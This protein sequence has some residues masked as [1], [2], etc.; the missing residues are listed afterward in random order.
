MGPSSSVLPRAA[1]RESEPRPGSHH[2][3]AAKKPP[4][5]RREAHQASTPTRS[6]PR[7]GGSS[8]NSTP[9]P[10]FRG[11]VATAMGSALRTAVSRV[12][13]VVAPRAPPQSSEGSYE[14]IS[15]SPFVASAPPRSREALELP[16]AARMA[17]SDSS[18]PSSL[19]SEVPINPP[20]GRF[21]TDRSQYEVEPQPRATFEDV[22]RA[23]GRLGGEPIDGPR[24]AANR[25]MLNALN[26]CGATPFDEAFSIFEAARPNW[27]AE[28]AAAPPQA[29]TV[30][31]VMEVPP[32]EVRS[33]LEGPRFGAH[34]AILIKTPPPTGPTVMAPSSVHRT[35]QLRGPSWHRSGWGSLLHLAAH[36]LHHAGLRQSS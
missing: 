6:V 9:G 5:F 10:R 24:H 36:S 1:P 8:P 29:G 14:N 35:R 22:S 23:M 11:V 12:G 7:F 33:A 34:K 28:L 20:T 3:H 27:R 31:H 4:A 2:E 32:D 19:W 30:P 15:Q 18:L 16:G 25:A 26:E 13:D 21:S 17:R